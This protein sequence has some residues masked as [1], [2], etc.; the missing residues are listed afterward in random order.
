MIGNTNLTLRHYY[1]NGNNSQDM[2]YVDIDGDP[3]TLN[4]SSATLVYPTGSE[5]PGYETID[6]ACT[7]VVYAGLYWMGRAHNSSPSNN[8]FTVNGKS[9]D[10][11]KVRFKHSG[12]SYRYVTAQN[13]EIYFPT[14]TQDFIYTGYADV[15]D[16][17]RQKGA[18]EYFVADI[19]LTEGA[20]Y[21]GAGYFG[22]WG[23]IVVYENSKMKW[24]DITIFDGYA[25]INTIQGVDKNY[26]LD[27]AGFRTAQKGHIDM[28]L[29]IIAGEGDKTIPGDYFEIQKRNS[30][31]WERLKHNGND[32][33]NFFYSSIPAS[34][35][36]NPQI[37]NNTGID[38]A[39]FRID[40]PDNAIINNKQTSTKFRYGS[41]SLIHI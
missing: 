23:L 28:R 24:R 25:Y 7:N 35:P 11:L 20:T 15:T 10:K 32:K 19:A 21:G 26:T 8:Q 16:Y 41:L 17:V 1:H 3:S 33:N 2:K 29:G 39:M 14:H 40:N 22:G 38:I 12:D 31:E 5:G 36:R 34:N 4:S 37:L 30:N 13:S 27:V 9:L 18:G 6:P